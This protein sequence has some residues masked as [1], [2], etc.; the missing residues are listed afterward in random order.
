MMVLYSEIAVAEER[1]AL[2]GKINPILGMLRF[3][4]WRNVKIECL[5]ASY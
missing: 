1:A 2:G 4:F 3:G 5:L